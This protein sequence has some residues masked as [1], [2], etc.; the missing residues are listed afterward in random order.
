MR[1]W[2]LLVLLPVS[3]CAPAAQLAVCVHDPAPAPLSTPRHAPRAARNVVLV[4]LDGVRW[5]EVFGGAD[6]ELARR[7]RVGGA[8]AAARDLLP[9]LAAMIDEGVALGR[10]EEMVTSSP[11]YVSLP[12]YLELL[13]G[14]PSRCASNLCAATESSTVVDELREELGLP[15]E[16]VAVIASWEVIE[17]AAARAP[18]RIV[19]SAGR[20]GGA[21]RDRLRVTPC[22][23]ATLDD[24]ARAAAYPG[25]G[26]YRPD[27]YTA[28]L[29]LEYLAARRPRFLYVA[30]GDTDERAHRGDYAGYLAALRSADAFVGALRAQL[31]ALG[32]YGAETAVLVTTD[33]GRARGFVHHGP[34]FPE[35][36]RV[37]M[38]AA[39]ASVTPQRVAAAQRL[40]LADVAPLIR[41]LVG[42]P[43][44]NG[45]TGLAALIGSPSGGEGQGALFAR[46]APRPARA[47]LSE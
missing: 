45:D 17:R 20:H 27:A 31:D 16:A 28:R 8:P 4:T 14:R 7:F 1:P 41:R 12:G 29:A 40:R 22:A 37:W 25:F 42:L 21:T 39:G 46:H 6:A 23:S 15:A 24:A 3:G 30:L 32:D 43:V 34:G 33:H 9:N 44:A 38:V 2:P 10:D 19:L 47:A 26:D 13:S 5:Q 36:G 35:S 18:A 11:S